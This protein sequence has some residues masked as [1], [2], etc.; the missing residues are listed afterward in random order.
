MS[1]GVKVESHL[2]MEFEVGLDLNPDYQKEH[3]WTDAQRVAYLEY[4]LL[5][6]EAGKTLIVA[7]VGG[8]EDYVHRPDETI[9]LRGYSL[10][11]G[12][13]RL[14]TV[15][16]FLRGEIRVF[17]G[18][19]GV[20]EGY[21]WSECANGFRATGANLSFRWLRVSVASKADLYKLYLKFNEGGTPHTAEEL[22]RV[23]T[24]EQTARETGM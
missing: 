24:L 1:G 17:A 11:D 22:D 15:R 21:L 23:R 4:M 7:C 10:V 13:Q 8:G 3:V 12:K 6:G 20:P 2:N 9:Y 5:G 19:R 14:E 16:R 18:V